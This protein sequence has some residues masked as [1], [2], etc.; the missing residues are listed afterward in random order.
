M[1]SLAPAVG[2]RKLYLKVM[3]TQAVN[4]PGPAPDLCLSAAALLPDPAEPPANPPPARQRLECA[5][6]ST[7]LPS[8]NQALPPTDPLAH[9][10]QPASVPSV[11]SCSIQLR[12]F[13]QMTFLE[14]LNF[15]HVWSRLVISRSPFPRN[16]KMDRSILNP[17]PVACRLPP[18]RPPG[19]LHHF[20]TVFAP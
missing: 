14:I 5:S 15:S 16:S 13:W 20:C 19:F 9:R 1:I 10:P 18:T 11:R 8:S 12:S 7:T 17:V 4:V 3:H 6:F 2:K